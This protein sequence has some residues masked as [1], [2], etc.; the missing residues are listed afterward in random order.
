[1][2]EREPDAPTVRFQSDPLAPDLDRD[3]SPAAAD[4]RR[5]ILEKDFDFVHGCPSMNNQA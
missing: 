3:P 5:F 2:I 1:L 4:A